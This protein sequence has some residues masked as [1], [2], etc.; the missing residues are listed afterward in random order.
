[1]MAEKFVSTNIDY[2]FKKALFMTL[3]VVFVAVIAYSIANNPTVRIVLFAYPELVFLFLI[4]EIIL[5]KFTGLR[6]LEYIRFRTL[7]SRTEHEE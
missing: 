6:L 3:E 2:G 4:I 7:F 1:M 5:G